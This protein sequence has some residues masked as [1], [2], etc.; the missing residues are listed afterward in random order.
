MKQR[1]H[2]LVAGSTSCKMKVWIL[3]EKG[4]CTVDL[5]LDCYYHFK[6]TVNCY[7]HFILFTN[8]VI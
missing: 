4:K 5:V 1:E 3:E 6:K 2:H 7:Y 8:Q